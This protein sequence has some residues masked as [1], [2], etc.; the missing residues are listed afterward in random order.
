M[1]DVDSGEEEK[2]QWVMDNVGDTPMK[3]KTPRGFHCYFRTRRGVRYGNKVRVR[4]EPFDFRHDGGFV[5]APPSQ[6][7]R[8]EYQWMGAVVPIDDLP[9]LRVSPLREPKRKKVFRLT[10]DSGEAT[11]HVSFQAR[12]IL[13]PEK[14]CLKIESVQGQN[15]SAALVRAV[16]T[17]RDCGRS[18]EQALEF[19]VSEWNQKCATPPWSTEEIVYAIR[20]HFQIS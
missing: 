9:I 16:C 8:G 2:L 4:G 14:Y 3:V 5:V 13:H 11:A 19:L 12:K 15:G 20:R 18:P 10:H 7:E 17:L 1:L 6:T